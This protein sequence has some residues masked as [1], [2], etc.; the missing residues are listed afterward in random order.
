MGS[1]LSLLLFRFKYVPNCF[2]YQLLSPFSPRSN[3]ENQQTKNRRSSLSALAHGWST[4]MG[5]PIAGSVAEDLAAQQHPTPVFSPLIAQSSRI[6]SDMVSS[7]LSPWSTASRRLREQG[8]LSSSIAEETASAVHNNDLEEEEEQVAGGDSCDESLI[9][10]FGKIKVA[11]GYCSEREE[12]S[13]LALLVPCL[14][15]LG[16]VYILIRDLF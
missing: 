13:F 6:F 16:F 2:H 9:N 3:A 10:A 15:L 4:M 7:L 5:H 12:G 8:T 14:N 1:Y 11:D